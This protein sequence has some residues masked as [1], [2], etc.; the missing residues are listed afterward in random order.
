MGKLNDIITLAKA[1]LGNDYKTYCRDMGYNFRIEW[2]ACFIS[3]LATKCGITDIIPVDMSCNSQIRKFKN[4]G[5]YLGK[6]GVIPRVA[7]I[8]YY[9][10]DDI[11]D[12]DHVGIVTAVNGDTITVIEGNNGN[13]PNDRV[14]TRTI[15]YT[16]YLIYGFARP[17]YAKY[18]GN[19]AEESKP[20]TSS[21]EFD[22]QYGP[23]PKLIFTYKYDD[24][25][26]ELQVMLNRADNAG[27]ATDGKYGVYTYSAVKKYTMEMGDFGPLCCLVQKRLKTLGFN[28]GEADGYI[29]SNSLAAIAEFQKKWGLGVGYLGGTDW[30]FLFR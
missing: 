18:D 8:V 24:Q 3:W 5:C 10:W 16:S 11:Y 6:Q 28:P 23:N 21:D 12:A 19:P 9:N 14:R 27:L 2:C 22:K 4:L 17:N 29:G 26:K 30:Y 25:V 15:K 1:Q 7:D 13:Q 20:D